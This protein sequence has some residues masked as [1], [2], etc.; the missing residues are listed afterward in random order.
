MSPVPRRRSGRAAS[1]AAD[2]RTERSPQ[3]HAPDRHAHVDTRSFAAL[4]GVQTLFG[5]HYIAAKSITQV[6]PPRPWS[7]IRASTAAVIL[8]LIAR[9]RGLPLPR[10]RSVLLRFAGLG[11]IGVAINQWLFVE[12]LFRTSPGHSALINTSMPV[13]VMRI[14]VVLGRERPTA[15]RLAGVGITILGVLVLIGP[16]R[17]DWRA[18][19]FRGD[20]LTLINAT[21]PLFLSLSSLFLA[22][23]GRFR[24]ARFLAFGALWLI[25]VVPGLIS[26]DLPRSPRAPG[27]SSS[28]SCLTDGRYALTFFASRRVAPRS[29]PSSSI[30]SRSSA[31]AWISLGFERPTQRLSPRPSSSLRRS[32][33]C[34]PRAPPPPALA[35]AVTREVL[36]A[37]V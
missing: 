5:L 10:D 20:I 18:E 19:A 23:S 17:L 1:A 3:R 15:R 14:A 25:P 4:I 2:R 33:P 13:L 28:A 27:R 11:L 9:A 6:I 7:L 8:V 12:G 22:A 35:R 24:R 37:L 29:S 31:Q 30:S 36:P 34:S 21:S 16:E 32:S 26:L